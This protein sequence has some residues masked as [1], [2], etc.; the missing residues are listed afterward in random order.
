[1]MVMTALDRGP[2]PMRCPWALNARYWQHVKRYQ[3]KAESLSDFIEFQH[4]EAA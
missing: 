2:S 4:G 1:M 3:F